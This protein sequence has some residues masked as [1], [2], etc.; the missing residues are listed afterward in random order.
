MAFQERDDFGQLLTEVLVSGIDEFR[1]A[2]GDVVA[3][4][5]ELGAEEPAEGDQRDE[6]RQK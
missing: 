4:L 5:D 3:L 6:N 1:Q 2:A